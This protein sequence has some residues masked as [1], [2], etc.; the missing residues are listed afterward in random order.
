MKFGLNEIYKRSNSMRHIFQE[1]IEKAKEARLKAYAP[2]SKFKVGSAVLTGNDDI[3][4]GCNIENAS[5]GLSIC[6]ERVAIFK[7]ISSGCKIIK[8]I[9]IIC[10]TEKPCS[11]CGACRQVMVEF[12]P[13]MEVIMVNLQNQTNIA[14]AKELLPGYFQ[15]KALKYR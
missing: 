7:A 9:A 4:T 8:A 11:P 13:E 10:D 5:F 15:G 14:K 12:S 1:L 2:Y 3:F 6:A